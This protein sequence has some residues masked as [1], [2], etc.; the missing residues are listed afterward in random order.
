MILLEHADSS[1]FLHYS[2]D[3]KLIICE[4]NN[5]KEGFYFT[6]EDESKTCGYPYIEITSNANKIALR[7]EPT[8]LN[9]VNKEWLKGWIMIWRKHIIH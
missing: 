7:V 1:K 2:N 3:D 5:N 9:I 8:I 4:E 6:F